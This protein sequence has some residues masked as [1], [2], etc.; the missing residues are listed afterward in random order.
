MF[1]I[2]ETPQKQPIRETTEFSP[3]T[4]A[5]I[6]PTDGIGAYGVTKPTLD[7]TN[8]NHNSMF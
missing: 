4:F 8:R 3:F 1:I 2:L 5:N 6:Q 7:L